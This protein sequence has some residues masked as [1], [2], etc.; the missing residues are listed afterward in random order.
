MSGSKEKL[1]RTCGGSLAEDVP[2]D[3]CLG[4]RWD[5]L[6][7][8]DGLRL[9][10][11]GWR[12]EWAITCRFCKVAGEG[13]QYVWRVEARPYEPVCDG[14]A[15]SHCWKCG[16]Q[17]DA[18]SALSICPTCDAFSAIGF[19]EPRDIQRKL[20]KEMLSQPRRQVTFIEAPTGLGKSALALAYAN[21]IGSPSTVVCT[22]TISLQGQYERD[23]KDTLAVKGRSNF[24]CTA[25]GMT[26]DEGECLVDQDA[27][28]ASEYH[29]MRDAI[30]DARFIVTNYAFYLTELV[31]LQCLSK[32]PSLLVCDEGHRLLD[33]LDQFSKS[34]LEAGLACSL[35]VPASA[36]DTMRSARA[37]AKKNI[38]K[39]ESNFFRAVKTRDSRAKKWKKL[40][41]QCQSVLAARDD[42]IVL[43]EGEL[44]EAAPLWPHRMA[45]QLL[46]SA[47]RETLIMSATL[48]GGHGLAELL[49]LNREEYGGVLAFSPFPPERWPV[50]FDPVARL[51]ARAEPDEWRKMAAAV[52]SYVHKRRDVKGI[53]HVTARAQVS[54]VMGAAMEC[55]ECAPR[56]ILP[57]KGITREETLKQFRKSPPGHW[58]CHYSVGE[59]E[60]FKDDQCR[61]QLITKVP[62]SALSDDLTKLRLNTDIGQGWY[63]SVT[64]SKIAQIAGRGMRHEGDFCETVI[65]DGSFAALYERAEDLFPKWFRK[66]LKRA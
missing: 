47:E 12:C 13:F 2:F 10:D 21:L 6:Q 66:L 37:W 35:G 40:L 50:H 8:V 17:H 51:S 54:E 42:Y 41:G 43:K 11:M 4:C 1:C 14:C 56:L 57:N 53:V 5:K 61:I 64:A 62:Y 31:R 52:H 45:R 23:F 44:F 30:P 36:W 65:L 25:N 28:C 26:A 24:S 60:D 48:Y 32:T 55:H 27:R 46:F 18:L 29:V 22:A 34:R 63:D 33:Q 16:Q 15:A 39:V 7:K 49:G 20:L 59:G 9:V 58:L 19:A 3:Q 38:E